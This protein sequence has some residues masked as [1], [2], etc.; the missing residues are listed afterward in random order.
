[1]DDVWTRVAGERR[2]LAD[3]LETLAPADWEVRSLSPDWTVRGVVAHVAWGPG[4][5][6]AELM[7]DLARSGFRI[8]RATA[9][10]ARRWGKREPALTGRPV[11]REELTGPGAPALYERLS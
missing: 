3:F 8:N 11:G 10:N 9:E 5:P 6:P 7:A 4:Q 1:V 2:A